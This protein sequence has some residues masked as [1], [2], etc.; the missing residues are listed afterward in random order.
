[1]KRSGFRK[2]SYEEIQA[3]Q[4]TRRSKLT[5]TG[6][7]GTGVTR[8]RK[9]ESPL[10]KLKKQLWQLCREITIKRDGSDCYT[11]PSKALEGSNR[12]LGHFISSSICS[13]ELRYDLGNLRIQCYS[14]NIN[15]SG[16]WLAYEN[17]LTREYGEDYVRNLKVRN[18][19]TKG[20]MYREDFYEN[21]I[22][23]YQSILDSL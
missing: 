5:A 22:A 16:N 21:K 14:C 6:S 9:K 19:Q 7:K 11:C 20:L 1:M 10:A 18:E 12:Q 2:Q 13:T 8:K 15:K 3:K 23:E 4:A 17:R